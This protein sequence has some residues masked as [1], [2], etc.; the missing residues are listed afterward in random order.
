MEMRHFG[1]E[2]DTGFSGDFVLLGFTMTGCFAAK[3]W[4]NCILP[5]VARSLGRLVHAFGSHPNPG[6]IRRAPQ[7]NHV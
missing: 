7:L 5:A 3:A 2:E 6:R 1:P 4:A